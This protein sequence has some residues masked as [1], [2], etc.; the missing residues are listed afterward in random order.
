MDWKARVE[1]RGR[2]ATGNRIIKAA[3]LRDLFLSKTIRNNLSSFF[4]CD[5]RR[6]IGAAAKKDNTSYL[7]MAQKEGVLSKYA[8]R[9]EH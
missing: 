9:I 5:G 2:R 4:H 8:N 6:L 7:L 1:A 3:R